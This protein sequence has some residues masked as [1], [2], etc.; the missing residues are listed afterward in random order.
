MGAGRKRALGSPERETFPGD[1]L[2]V[3]PFAPA[4]LPLPRRSVDMAV[5]QPRQ[6]EAPWSLLALQLLFI[7]WVSSLLS[8]DRGGGGDAG[9]D[10][11]PGVAR[12]LSVDALWGLR[13]DAR[14]MF[15]HGYDAY[16][17]HGYPWDEVKPLSCMG[18]RWDVR[19]RG[20]LDDPLGGM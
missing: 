8:G 12:A 2:P 9:G 15:Y 5:A 10:F 4:A 18:R 14:D 13:E 20:T 3:G 6:R 7:L 1:T 11:I 16:M 17:A 19:E